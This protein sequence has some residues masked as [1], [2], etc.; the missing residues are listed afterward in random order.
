MATSF[1]QLIN[2]FFSRIEE[3]REFFQYYSLSDEEALNLAQ[4]R[5]QHYLMNAVDR[6]MLEGCPEI[7]FSDMDIALLQFNVDLTSR[8]I[9]ILASLMYE[10]YLEKDISK[11]KI[12]DNSFTPTELRVFDK[13]NL[14]NSF[15]ALYDG[16]CQRNLEMLDS[17]RNTDRLT[18]AYKGIDFAAFDEEES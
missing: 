17:Y 13:S 9:F 16:V 4:T 15:K 2:R 12:M 14:R 8:E 10:Y 11:I 3:D 18:G 6:M 7:D 5:A 1:T